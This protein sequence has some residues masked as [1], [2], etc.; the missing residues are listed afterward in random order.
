MKKYVKKD[1][2][3][4]KTTDL[5]WDCNCPKIYIHSIQ[6]KVCEHCGAIRADQPDSIAS[7]V[8]DMFSHKRGNNERR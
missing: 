1:R 8:V 4:P 5:Y 6:E 3:P 7:E 2:T